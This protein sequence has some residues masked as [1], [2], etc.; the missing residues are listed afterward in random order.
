[1]SG[2][3]WDPSQQPDLM[4]SM[5]SFASSSLTLA[6]A[7]PMCL[8]DLVCCLL[9]S[10]AALVGAVVGPVVEMLGQVAVLAVAAMGLEDT[11]SANHTMV[12]GLTL[13]TLA[14]LFTRLWASPQQNLSKLTSCLAGILWI[15][16]FLSCPSFGPAAHPQAVL[17]SLAL[18]LGGLCVSGLFLE[19]SGYK[20]NPAATDL[21]A[22]AGGYL[23]VLSMEAM[24]VMVIAAFG[25]PGLSAEDAPS[26]YYC[27]LPFI[28]MQMT[29]FTSVAKVEAPVEVTANGS[30]THIQDE[31]SSKIQEVKEICG[32]KVAEVKEKIEA[33]V[34]K[35]VEENPEVLEAAA[36]VEAAGEIVEAKV[37]EIVEAVKETVEAVA[38]AVDTKVEEVKADPL[39]KRLM[40]MLTSL[41]TAV[42]SRLSAL[43]APILAVV[44]A[45]ASRLAAV[46]WAALLLL[47]STSGSHLLH[48]AAW[49]H[50]TGD[51]LALALPALTLGL[52]L[53]LDT[54]GT[55]LPACLPAYARELAAVPTSLAVAGVT[56]LLV[57]GGGV[58]VEA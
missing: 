4:E 31:L 41:Y 34:E 7:L 21:D 11:W 53:L 12:L 17:L 13:Y 16:I 36:K 22:T 10:V 26:R 9:V 56:Y 55:K 35:V 44:S 46:P 45:V 50:L 1:M 32:D 2:L 14:A 39:F 20:H 51:S 15:T 5:A 29:Y 37:E 43:L 24:G 6:M 30:V 3:L 58:P 47:L 54:L 18:T 19:H 23:T 48:G 27:I 33:A 38:E 57:T 49:L 8:I 40:A 42:A 28:A 52:P 25:Y